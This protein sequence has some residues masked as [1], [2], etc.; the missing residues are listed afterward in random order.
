MSLIP[1]KEDDIK[2]NFIIM[3][4]IPGVGKTTFAKRLV[5]TLPESTI[6]RR[7]EIRFELLQE[8][9]QQGEPC[10]NLDRRVD[11]V[12]GDR[13]IDEIYTKQHKYVIL[14]GCHTNFRSTL[15]L[16]AKI[17]LRDAD[18]TLTVI[19]VGDEFS[20]SCH[21]V[22][23]KKEDDYSDFKDDGTFEFIPQAVIERKREELS[24]SLTE[25]FAEL[26]FAC[27]AFHLIPS[28]P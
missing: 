11:D 23:Q 5:A 9:K 4:G 21:S 26:R 16:L 6:I 12:E 22:N 27:N 20:K 8:L 25:N 28:F 10:T 13:V 19:C 1:I 7:D 17:K 24:I 14:D 3:M 15:Y 2:Q 18:T